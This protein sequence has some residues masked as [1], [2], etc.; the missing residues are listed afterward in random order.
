MSLGSAEQRLANFLDVPVG[1]ASGWR[2][3]LRLHPSTFR[4]LGRGV[5]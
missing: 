1:H 4:N 3:R 5:F 2:G